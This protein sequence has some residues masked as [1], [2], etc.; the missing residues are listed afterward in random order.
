[1]ADYR[2]SSG[3][4]AHLRDELVY[5]HGGTGLQDTEGDPKTEV[6]ESHIMR[7]RSERRRR[8]D[9]DRTKVC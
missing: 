3:V 6:S 8:S 1:M 2:D 9:Y 4:A 7:P 5:V